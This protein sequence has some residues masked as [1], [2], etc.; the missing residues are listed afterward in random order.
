MKIISIT[1]LGNVGASVL[2]SFMQKEEALC[3][4]IIDPSSS[5]EGKLLDIKHAFKI[6]N[7]N[8]QLHLNNF[9]LYQK[10]DFIIHTAGAQNKPNTSRLEVLEENRKITQ[11]LFEKFH[12]KSHCN[13]IVVSNPVDIISY[14]TWK[15]S[16]INNER[17]IGTGTLLDSKRLA[18][19]IS[20]IPEFSDSKINAMVLG[21]HGDSQVSI[22]SQCTIN[23]KPLLSQDGITDSDLSI[24][25]KQTTKSAHRIRKTQGSTHYGVAQC[26]IKIYDDL[27]SKTKQSYPLSVLLNEYYTNLFQLEKPIYISV[28]TQV[29]SLGVQTI[30]TNSFLKTELEALVNS[31]KLIS[32]L[33]FSA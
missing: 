1:G 22:F 30:D 9:D 31:A 20:C 21:E 7:K 23:G 15:Y 29:S 24:L 10:S 27:H 8:H 14:Y 28:P 3:F 17:V 33:S 18:Y 6:A 5:I 16:G 19:E 32:D 4:N 13:V 12:F 25:A 11:E 2:F 26:V